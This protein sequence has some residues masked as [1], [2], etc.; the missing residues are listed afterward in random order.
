MWYNRVS[1]IVRQLFQ[2]VNLIADAWSEIAERFWR[3]TGIL[4]PLI[5]SFWFQYHRFDT[6]FLVL[7]MQHDKNLEIFGQVKTT[8]QIFQN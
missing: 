1:Y 3:V 8:Q 2:D 4:R 7:S 5:Q 6:Q